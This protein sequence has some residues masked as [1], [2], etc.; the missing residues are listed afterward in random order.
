MALSLAAKINKSLYRLDV[1]RPQE[2]NNEV[3]VLVRTS[4][5]KFYTNSYLLDNQYF[6]RLN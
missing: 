4:N 2:Q 6:Y 1:D 3:C 5:L